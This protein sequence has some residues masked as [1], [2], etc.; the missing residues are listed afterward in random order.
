M[1]SRV[2]IK[3]QILSK[4]I[5]KA[6][7]QQG[8]IDIYV[9]TKGEAGRGGVK[10]NVHTFA[11]KGEGGVQDWM[12]ARKISKLFFFCAKEAITLPFIIVYRTV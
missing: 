8:V 10:P 11:D 1:K 3:K 9:C 7:V 2:S 5:P 4:E 12:L 6:F